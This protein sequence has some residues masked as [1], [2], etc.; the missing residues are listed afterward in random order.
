MST[1]KT[2]APR[3]R[4]QL[5]LDSNTVFSPVVYAIG[6][7]SLQYVEDDENTL[8]VGV[9]DNL[10]QPVPIGADD[11]SIEWEIFEQPGNLHRPIL[12]A[13]GTLESPGDR[14][15][16]YMTSEDGWVVGHQIYFPAWCGLRG[17]NGEWIPAFTFIV[18]ALPP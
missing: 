14:A 2:G 8:L 10:L 16:L 6:L 15:A 11:L 5:P 12:I 13:P 1:V 4:R 7:E 17:T 3:N 9:V 18:P